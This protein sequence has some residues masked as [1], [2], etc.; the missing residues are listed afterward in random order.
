MSPTTESDNYV[1][2]LVDAHPGQGLT[3]RIVTELRAL[4][5]GRALQSR[6][7][8]RRI[9]S[10]LRELACG[11]GTP[12][13]ADTATTRRRLAAELESRASLLSED[14]R[15]AIRA[16]LGLSG[17]TRQ[18]RLF[19]DRASWLANQIDREY[20]TAL[21]RIDDAEQL[22]AEEIAVELH[23]R[24]S[25]AATAPQGWYLDDFRVVLRLD[26]P[27]PQSMEHRRIIAARADLQEI[28]AWVDVPG[29]GA[30]RPG[31]RASAE[32][33]YGGRLVR[34]EQPSPGRFQFV[35]Q[36]PVALQPGDQHEYGLAMRMPEG[37][38]MRPH[39]IFVPECIC[40]T[41]DLTVRFDLGHPP[42]W[43]RRVD[44]EPVRVFDAARPPARSISLDE[45]G[46]VHV[47]F[48]RPEM[49]LGYGLQWH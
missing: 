13:E 6:D 42:A 48:T 39:A 40:N 5:K 3:E 1:T 45:S 4:R 46:E 36:L 49:N 14:A 38:T 11:G 19:S 17:Q 15:A 25:Q 7:L 21:R 33:M 10:H 35:V 47:R 34:R 8:D 27:T 41:F 31:P 18:M 23:R 29:D 16:S 26:T 44:G 37:E 30:G 43:V 20:R 22:L 2:T 28:M 9:G 24:R 12:V 32:V